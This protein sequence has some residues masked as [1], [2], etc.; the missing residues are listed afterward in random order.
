MSK[1]T[2]RIMQMEKLFDEATSV[3]NDFEKNLN[4]YNRIQKKIDQL[5][6]YYF[7]SLWRK[8]YED[9]EKGKIKNIKK[10]VLSQD[11]IYNMLINNDELLKKL[12]KFVKKNKWEL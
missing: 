4:K 12:D 2:D 11:G 5:E 10:G 8:D 7:S 1:Q 6:E 3:I 9:D